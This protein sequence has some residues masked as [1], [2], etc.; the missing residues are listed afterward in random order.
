M[1]QSFPPALRELERKG[2][3]VQLRHDENAESKE[4]GKQWK[5]AKKE[6]VSQKA[7]EGDEVENL[8]AD[9]RPGVGRLL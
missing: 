8:Y 9:P 2:K 6:G 4:G 1:Y 3:P 5:W 7:K